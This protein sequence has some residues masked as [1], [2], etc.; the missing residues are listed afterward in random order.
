MADSP[1]GISPSGIGAALGDVIGA[2]DRSFQAWPFFEDRHRVFARALGDWV[3]RHVGAVGHTEASVDSAAR[4][5]VRALADGGWLTHCVADP[6]TDDASLDVR[7]LCLARETLAAADG[8]ADFAFAMQGL[9]SGP[10]SLFGSAAQRHGYLPAVRAGPQD[11]RLRL[12][13]SRGGLGRRGDRDRGP[14]RGQR[15]PAQRREDLDLERRHCRFLRRVRA[16]RRSAGRQG[17]VGLPGRRHPDRLQRHQA[18]ADHRSASDRHG[19]VQQLPTR[20]R[21]A[22]RQAGRGLQDRHGD[23][24]RVPRHGRRGG[25]R[26]RPACARRSGDPRARARR[27]RQAAGRVAND[28]GASSPTWRPMSTP[29]RC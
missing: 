21:C 9:G 4:G 18:L 20:R 24:R 2:F 27:V 29:P 13:G 12:V 6:T 11:R 19:R 28:P 16:H 23:A 10:I 17:P 5:Y 14:A 7:T 8:L 3:L 22:D 26:L 1:S 25:A 15:F